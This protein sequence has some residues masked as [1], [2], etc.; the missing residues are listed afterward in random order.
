MGEGKQA[1][2]KRR[3]AESGAVAGAVALL[4]GFWFGI[5]EPGVLVAFGVVIGAVPAGITWLVETIK[6]K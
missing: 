1:I 2:V 3:P 4:L 5:D 6:P